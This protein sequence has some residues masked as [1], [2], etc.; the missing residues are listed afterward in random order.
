MKGSVLIT[1]TTD[2]V[3]GWK[4]EMNLILSIGWLILSIFWIV[5]GKPFIEVCACFLLFGIFE[6]I[7]EI[8][9]LR[10]DL[11]EDSDDVD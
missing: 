7:H 9:L 4:V 5:A 3:K 11:E 6:G 10:E 1:I 2:L 8:K